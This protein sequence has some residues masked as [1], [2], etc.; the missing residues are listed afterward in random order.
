MSLQKMFTV[1]IAATFLNLSMTGSE[2]TVQR[3]LR[4]LLVK[5]TGDSTK[6]KKN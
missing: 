3:K 2:C 6:K 5:V 1:A 4:A